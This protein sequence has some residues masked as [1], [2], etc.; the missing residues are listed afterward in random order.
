MSALLDNLKEYLQI[1]R[2][3]GSKLPRVDVDLRKF[4]EFLE[5]EGHA[6]I[7]TD[8]ALRWACLSKEASPA[9]WAARLTKVRVFARYL[10]AKDPRH[11]IPPQ[12]LLPFKPKRATPYRY[13]KP[14]I[15]ALLKAASGLPS[16]E[17]LRKHTYATVFGL[18]SVTGMRISEIVALDRDDVDLSAGVLKIRKTKFDKTRLVPLHATTREALNAY[19]NLRDRILPLRTSEAFFLSERGTRLTHWIVRHTFVKLS[20]QIGLRSPQDSRGPRIHDFRH[21]FALETLLN[22]YRQDVDAAQ[23]LPELATYLGH[24][25]VA[26]TYWYLQAIPELLEL[27]SRRLERREGSSK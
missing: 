8:L 9:S 10:H 22:W 19:A 2:L 4:I 3:L 7:T 23:H 26:D 13:E 20:R 18:L 12:E 1:R 21:G 5:E 14:Q 11:Q 6:L 16:K 25:H 24:G 15:L 17:G 27:A